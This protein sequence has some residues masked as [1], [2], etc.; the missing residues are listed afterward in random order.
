MTTQ[1]IWSLWGADELWAG[2]GERNAL[3][4]ACLSTP[5]SEASTARVL[6]P[7]QSPDRHF[8]LELHVMLLTLWANTSRSFQRA[9][10][11]IPRLSA[12]SQ[13]TA[14]DRELVHRRRQ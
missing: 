4:M 11:S 14:N 2:G 3:S 7:R 6:P 8:F 5:Y 12:N 1:A 10:G 9:N 13:Q